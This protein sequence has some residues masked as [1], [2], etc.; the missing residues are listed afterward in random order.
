[1]SKHDEGRRG[2]AA[3]DEPPAAISR[4]DFLRLAGVAA[5]AGVATMPGVREA[6]AEDAQAFDL[7]VDV[8]VVGSGA[9]GS[10]AALA[11]HE[12][13]A[14]V[15]LLEKAGSSEGNTEAKEALAKVTSL[16]ESTHATG[17]E[18]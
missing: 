5:A 4:R 9:A 16:V 17:P 11:A 18:C 14:K 7:E 13:G 8:V 2:D 10:V 12:A 6:R 15:A 3:G 1:M